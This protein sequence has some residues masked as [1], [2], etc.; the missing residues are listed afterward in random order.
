MKRPIGLLLSSCLFLHLVSAQFTLME[1]LARYPQLSK[2]TALITNSTVLSTRFL[3]QA[4]NFTLLAPTDTAISTWLSTNVSQASVEAVLLYHLL[5]GRH[6]IASISNSSVAI[7]T[8]L[9][10]QTY[11][12]VTGGQRVEALSTGVVEFQSDAKAVS[13]VVT[14]VRF[15]SFEC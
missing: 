12:N 9:T 10:N 2:L 14:G 3:D 13:K 4:T 11:A 1:V 8:A 6:P 5:D 15:L 7:P